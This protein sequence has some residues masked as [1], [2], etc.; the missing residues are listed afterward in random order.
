MAEI[1]Q[2]ETGKKKKGA[3]KKMDIHVD[4]TPMVDMNMLL[5]S[6]FMLCTTMIK[7][8][9]LNITLPSN[10]KNIEQKDLAK[11]AESEAITMIL[12]SEYNEDGQVEDNTIYY[13]FGKPFVEDADK[14][15][16]IDTPADPSLGVLHAEKFV[17]DEGGIQQ[18]I[19]AILHNRNEQVLEKIDSL[20]KIWQN[21]ANNMSKEEYEAKAKVIRNDSTLTRPVVVIKAT[22]DASWAS[23]ISALDEMQINQI[24]R[25]QINEINGVDSLLIQDYLIKQKLQR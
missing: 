2:K 11:A 3:Q 23:V 15:D 4:F 1:Q 16:L 19:R 10:D 6:F 17:G 21:K 25:Y 8:Q 13:Y 5:I 18:G 9:T 20:K 24:T 12:T 22:P 14:D 7:S